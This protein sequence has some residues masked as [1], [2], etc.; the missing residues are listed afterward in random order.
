MG[1]IKIYT[2]FYLTKFKS[3]KTKPNLN[4]P[5][6]VVIAN[7]LESH[8]INIFNIL[9]TPKFVNRNTFTIDTRKRVQHNAETL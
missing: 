4:I 3:A 1:F 5:L 2:I 7:C 8:I 6:K 9:Y